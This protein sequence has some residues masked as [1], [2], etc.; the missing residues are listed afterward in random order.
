[1]TRSEHIEWCKKRALEYADK[2]ELLTALASMASDLNKHPE[3]QA[4]CE[5]ET[6]N[7]EMDTVLGEAFANILDK[8]IEALRWCRDSA[9][10]HP[11][12]L[13]GE[14]WNKVCTPLLEL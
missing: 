12:G 9:D 6:S 14:G 11:E 4:W 1:M 2:G 7:I 10:F 8:Y 5:P 3:T 13:A